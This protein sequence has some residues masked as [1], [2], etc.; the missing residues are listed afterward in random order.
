MASCDAPAQ[1]AWH[2]LI[3]DWNSASKALR[4]IRSS[5][6]QYLRDQANGRILGAKV[7][8]ALKGTNFLASIGRLNHKVPNGVFWDTCIAFVA[9]ATLCQKNDL[10]VQ[11]CV[12]ACMKALSVWVTFLAYDEKKHVGLDASLR[13]IYSKKNPVFKAQWTR[14][15]RSMVTWVRLAMPDEAQRTSFGRTISVDWS[16]IQSKLNAA[17]LEVVKEAAELQKEK[18]TAFYKNATARTARGGRV[19]PG[20]LGSELRDAELLAMR[21]VLAGL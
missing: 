4:E 8:H 5:G 21:G 9:D 12:T 18:V 7:R 13:D 10:P 6:T 16:V 1:E 17:E 20:R 3:L 15:L 2:A 14:F 11:M 19:V